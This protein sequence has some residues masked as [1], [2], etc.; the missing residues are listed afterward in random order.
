MLHAFWLAEENLAFVKV[1]FIG[2]SLE[3]IVSKLVFTLNKKGTYQS[4]ENV[5]DLGFF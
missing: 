3:G 5:S 1:V 4:E 2:G